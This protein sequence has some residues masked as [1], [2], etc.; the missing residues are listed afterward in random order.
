MIF[1]W[2]TIALEEFI[3]LIKFCV[4]RNKP[5]LFIKR[6]NNLPANDPAI[7]LGENVS[8]FSFLS[9]PNVMLSA[10]CI[11]VIKFVARKENI[12]LLH[13]AKLYSMVIP[14]QMFKSCHV[15]SLGLMLSLSSQTSPQF[16]FKL[17]LIWFCHLTFHFII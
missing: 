4:L 15:L 11:S 7:S 12:L 1:K 2:V 5:C 13:C 17:I 8:F 6:V 16:T 10:V 14:R 3:G 9:M